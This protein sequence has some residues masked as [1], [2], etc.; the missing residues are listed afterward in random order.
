MEFP[1]ILKADLDGGMPAIHAECRARIKK[2]LSRIYTGYY[3][4]IPGIF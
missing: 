3:Q 4:D 2:H 1:A